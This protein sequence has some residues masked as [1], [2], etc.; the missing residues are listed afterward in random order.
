MLAIQAAIGAQQAIAT[1]AWTDGLAVRVRMGIHSGRPSL[2]SGG[3]VGLSVHAAAR[4]CRIAEGGQI[5]VSRA[6]VQGLG[7]S[8]GDGIEL[9]SIG[10]HRLRG[11]PQA[12][13]LFE[14]RGAALAG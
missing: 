7:E 4:I 9:L 5:V 13:E 2:S 10:R 12:M 6:A 3:Y 8:I 11:L 1:H 14:V